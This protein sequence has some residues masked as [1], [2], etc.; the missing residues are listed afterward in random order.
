ML[1]N[2]TQIACIEINHATNNGNGFSDVAV[3]C[4]ALT[5]Y[6]HGNA[7]A[8][9]WW[10]DLKTGE[11]KVRNTGELLMLMVSELAEAMEGDR[12][13]KMDE[14]LPNRKSIEVELADCVIRI[15]DFAGFNGLDLGGA[16]FE[17]LQYNNKRADHKP[18]NRAKQDGKKY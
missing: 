18:E 6:C 5:N 14:H 8:N 15:F 2:E 4:E 11:L 9:G 17:K 16:I 1:L 13:N 12:K 10:H 3:A 7:F